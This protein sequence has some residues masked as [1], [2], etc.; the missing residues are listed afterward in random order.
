MGHRKSSLLKE[1]NTPAGIAA[2]GLL[3]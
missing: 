1:A 2:S 3:P